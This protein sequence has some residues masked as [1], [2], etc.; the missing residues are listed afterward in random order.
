MGVCQGYE[1]GRILV[2]GW[3]FEQNTNSVYRLSKQITSSPAM[4]LQIAVSCS[5][6]PFTVGA[7]RC[8][9]AV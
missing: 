7:N 3:H 9:N 8:Q 6:V 5:H 4:L 2:Y 1:R